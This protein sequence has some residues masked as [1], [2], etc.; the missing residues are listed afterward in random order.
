MK[1]KNRLN[2]IAKDKYVKLGLIIL[3]ITFINNTVYNYLEYRDV[4]MNSPCKIEN[5]YK[6][7]EYLE[8]DPVYAV[9]RN[10]EKLKYEKLD[11]KNLYIDGPIINLYS[12][13]KG[14]EYKSANFTFGFKYDE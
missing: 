11:V 4:S 10:K 6:N 3:C 9:Y 8:D 2:K 14:E 5:F 1:K 7:E 13:T 12:N